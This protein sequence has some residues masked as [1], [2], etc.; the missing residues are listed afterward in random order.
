MPCCRM[1]IPAKERTLTTRG[2]QSSAQCSA[3]RVL[4]EAAVRQGFCD[5]Q[6]IELRDLNP[7]T[8]CYGRQNNKF[9]DFGDQVHGQENLGTF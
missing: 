6:G 7:K 2:Q 8:S 4:W 9:C 3:G 1:G 5:C